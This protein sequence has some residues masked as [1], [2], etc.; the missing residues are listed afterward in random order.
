[1]EMNSGTG[2]CWYWILQDNGVLSSNII[3]SCSCF[4]FEDNCIAG[5]FNTTFLY[6][7]MLGGTKVPSVDFNK[8][9]ILLFSTTFGTVPHRYSMHP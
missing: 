5:F 6:D 4:S 3:S 2:G 7:I 9:F 8:M 1:M